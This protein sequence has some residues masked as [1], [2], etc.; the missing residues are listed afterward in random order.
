MY[1]EMRK[2]LDERIPEVLNMPEFFEG[3]LTFEMGDVD[4]PTYCYYE[5][6]EH[7]FVG[8]VTCEI[9]DDDLLE[10][11]LDFMEDMANSEDGGV[12]NLMQIQIL[13]GLFGLDRDVFLKM[14]KMLRPK[15]KQYLEK[16]KH[17][18]SEPNGYVP[19]KINSQSTKK[20]KKRN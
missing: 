13:D 11:I 7:L 10:R 9:I 17:G 12:G 20:K 5:L 14:E 8:L 19:N 16:S 15:T 18:F 1:E 2:V 3:K 4:I 6:L